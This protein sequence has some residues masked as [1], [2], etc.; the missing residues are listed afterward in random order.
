MTQL[1]QETKTR[2]LVRVID[3]DPGIL[4]GLTFL[5]T[6]SGWK[7]VGYSSAEE[8]LEKDNM[9]V[10]GCI[11]LDIRMPGMTGIELQTELK[12]QR[13]E[14]PVIII[15]GHADVD[16][17]VRTL[18]KGAFDFLQKPVTS[19]KLEEVLAECIQNKIVADTGKNEIE[20]LKIY[21]AL[22]H[23]EQEILELIATGLTSKLIGER[24]GLS[25]RTVQGHRLNISKKFNIHSKKELLACWD[26][27]TKK[28][29]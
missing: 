7:S 11:L 1:T 28:G 16:T 9:A 21:D 15:T 24:L 8:F 19:D 17:A 22:S 6:C 3:D 27:I 23:R 29:S 12:R 26:F 2:F 18:K 5:L 20:V 13:N 25:E 10:P 4:T 14:L